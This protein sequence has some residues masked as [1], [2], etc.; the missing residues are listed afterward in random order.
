MDSNVGPCAE[1]DQENKLLKIQQE[2]VENMPEYI[3]FN[4]DY[5]L[6]EEKIRKE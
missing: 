5:Q 4:E 1:M 2:H 6:E 3:G